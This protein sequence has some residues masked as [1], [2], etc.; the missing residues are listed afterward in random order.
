MEFVDL[1]TQQ[2]RIRPSLDARISNVLAHGKYIMGSEVME[3]E[4]VLR[5]FTQSQ[6]CI[7]TSSGTDALLMALMALGV[8]PGDEV[9]LPVYSFFATCEVVLL[10]QA[11]PVFVDIE[12][13]TFNIDAKLLRA[14]VTANTRA[15]IV[16][17]LFGQCCDYAE[18][19][20]LAN[21]LGL[22]VIEDAAQSFGATYK[23]DKSMNLATIG[24]TSFFPSKPLGC[25]GDGGACTTND[26]DLADKLKLIR[27]HGQRSRYKHETLGLNARLDTFQAAVLLCK[28]EIFED[29]ILRRQQIAERYDMLF[30]DTG[31][32]LQTP[33]I[34][35]NG[36]SVYA[37]YAVLVKERDKLQT[38]L[39]RNGIPTAIHYPEP[40][41]RQ[42]VLTRMAP[43]SDEFPVAEDISKQILCL[44][45][46]PYL[47]PADQEKVVSGFA[48]L[49]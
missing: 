11:K 39:N 32:D 48:A 4:E 40:M 22:P 36:S 24:C 38:S 14:K 33:S 26:S 20:N 44:P 12:K 5:D 49:A 31:L 8:G 1:K 47:S 9:I 19:N 23:G 13:D 37:Q 42:K 34:K 27:D 17:N 45:M 16:V 15:I 2:D 41:N 46:H 3:L 7:S 6:H 28:L 35:A 29:E 25:Y 43:S 30:A 10:L 21:E 18:I